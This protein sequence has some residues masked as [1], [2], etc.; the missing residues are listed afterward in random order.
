MFMLLSNI[1]LLS[2]KLTQ[3]LEWTVWNT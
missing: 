1:F 2:V 3:E